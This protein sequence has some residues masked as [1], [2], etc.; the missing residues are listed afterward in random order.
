MKLTVSRDT[1]VAATAQLSRIVE[2]RN[3]IPILSNLL[4]RA[5][6]DSLALTATD[7][8][9]EETCRI[10]AEVAEPGAVT[11]PA[12]QLKDITAKMAGES[13][14]IEG[15][16]GERNQA[17]IK[18]GRSRF[19]LITLPEADFPSL[20]GGEMPATW[21][22]PAKD[23]LALLSQVQFAIS[24]EETRYYLNGIHL[25]VGSH[26]GAPHLTAVATDGHRLALR[27]MPLPEG[28]AEL[29]PIILPR[30]AVSEFVK[31]LPS[32][33]AADAKVSVSTTKL[34][35]EVGTATLITKLID[36]TF[37]EYARVIPA[38]GPTQV[39]VNR[40]SLSDACGRVG[41]IS[42]ERVRSVKF[43][44]DKVAVTL[45]VTHPDTGEATDA[46]ET[47]HSGPPIEI[48]FN[49]GYMQD[50]AGATE[51]EQIVLSLTDPGSP[52]LITGAG[53]PAALFVL[54]PMRVG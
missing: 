7:L 37:P 28:A 23:L 34:R 29:P 8:D 15:A 12:V 54:M 33:A 3:T 20:D 51:A 5:T 9:L 36:G 17:I 49:G 39:T 16:T 50:I 43:T 41:A 44:F 32:W 48:G 25:H 45:T 11:L 52:T 10:K 2:R 27:R 31:I 42:T 35:L 6:G 53:D 40:K 47:E 19:A 46:V 13:I 1:L 14:S 4:L 21:S 22:M 24:T 30:K 26:A 38:P 18:S